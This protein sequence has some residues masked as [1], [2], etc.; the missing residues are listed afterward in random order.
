[1]T[2]NQYDEPSV[3]ATADEPEAV[4]LEADTDPILA[5]PSRIVLSNGETYLVERLKTRGTLRLLRIFTAGASDV[6]T[7]TSF[8]VDMDPDE[9]AG[10]FIGSLLF[11][12]PEQEQETIDFLKNIVRPARFISDPRTP[13]EREANANEMARMYEL[14]EDPETEDTFQIVS[15]LITIEAP[16]FLSLGK[17]IAT[18]L[19]VQRQSRIAK[20]LVT[21]QNS[22]P[23]V[24]GN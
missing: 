19:K 20:G 1:M 24:G 21:P 15:A 6:L 23:N 22:S 13:Q 17:R 12:I 14:L 4:S 5:D 3:P 10:I 7:Q 8:S 18:L 11:S 16:H 9:F 2:T